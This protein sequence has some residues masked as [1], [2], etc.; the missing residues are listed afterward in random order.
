MKNK[1]FL[2]LLN[3]IITF[4]SLYF[5]YSLFE[6]Y[7]TEQQNKIDAYLEKRIKINK[8]FMKNAF[9]TIKNEIKSNEKILF[10]LHQEAMEILK[11]HGKIDI[12]SLKIELKKRYL[13]SDFDFHLFYINKNYVIEESTYTND[14][15]FDLSLVPDARK[16][17]DQTNIDGLVHQSN[18]ISID[19]INSDV[20]SYSYSKIHDSFYLE[21]GFI[22]Q[23]IKSIL[24]DTMKNI[25]IM[26]DKRSQLYRIEQKL[27]NTQYYDNILI[28]KTDLSKEDYIKSREKFDKDMPTDNPIINSNRDE[29]IIKKYLDNAII[30]YIPLIKKHNQYLN[31]M[32]DF[33]LELYIDMQYEKELNER[34]TCYYYIFIM[35]HLFFLF[36]IYYFTKKYHDSQSA[37]KKEKELKVLVL[38]EN[39]K[40][41]NLMIRQMGTPLSVIINNF[42]FLQNE[43]DLKF[44]K[45][46]TQVNSGI[47]MLKKSYDDLEY[48]VSDQ[49]VIYKSSSIDLKRF[50]THRIEFF[51]SIL[52]VQHR[53]LDF[54][55]D[56]D[57]YVEMSE[58][59]LE[60][61]IDNNLSN[62]IK[63]SDE[64]STLF[65]KL[66][67]VKDTYC[68]SFSSKSKPIVDTKK[69]FDKNYQEH[70]DAKRSLG[71][72]LYMV[73]TICKKY[74]ISYEVIYENE[75]NIFQYY[76]AKKGYIY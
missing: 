7:K 74:T 63:Y 67:Q 40:F 59:E 26:T 1:Y 46:L 72:G 21:I 39:K 33:V 55:L 76:F 41:M 34:I 24:K 14:I 19:I 49:N 5:T 62:A 43:F 27:D 73:K 38:Q 22:N 52:E 45:Y 71:L 37:L 42:T 50:L 64:N 6:N 75:M 11:K 57:I 15:G 65:I 68:L 36:T 4:V 32:G 28:R 56:D 10:Q 44:Q 12:E 47:T 60:R 29:R 61:L 3:I 31:I 13:I 18:T 17:L 8:S 2:I 48:L 70:N 30:F 25:L 54:S 58:V 20:K 9:I 23:N 16:E 35:I 53:P 69:I 51:S 66:S